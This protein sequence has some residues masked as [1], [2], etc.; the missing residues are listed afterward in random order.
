MWSVK[1]GHCACALAIVVS[2]LVVPSS[3]AHGAESALIP[4]A[5]TGVVVEV[6]TVDVPANQGRFVVNWAPVAGAVA[7]RAEAR[8]AGVLRSSATVV[9]PAA[10]AVIEGLVGGQRYD[11][12]VRAASAGG[13]GAPSSVVSATALTVPSY[14]S[15]TEVVS[16][17]D[18]VLVRWN[19]PTNNGGAPVTK[20]QLDQRLSA[21][22]FSPLAT[23]IDPGLS[24]FAVTTDTSK[25]SVDD[26]R[27]LAYNELGWSAVSL[28]IRPPNAPRN[29]SASVGEASA[30]LEW[31]PPFV[32]DDQRAI[33]EYEVSFSTR[34]PVART[35]ATTYRLQGLAA[36]SYTVSVA[37]VDVDGT[38][39]SPISVIVSL[40][41]S[42]GGGGPV[43]PD[44]TVTPSASPSPSLSPTPTPSASP[45]P[46]PSPPSPSASPLPRANMPTKVT[47]VRGEKARMRIRVQGRSH[48]ASMRLI[49]IKDGLS[50]RLKVVFRRTSGGD[51][52]ATFTPRMGSGSYPMRLTY[53]QPGPAV[54]LDRA[55]LV[56]RR[57]R[58]RTRL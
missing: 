56:V 55:R 42:G 34:E 40:S 17:D 43:V 16:Q 1:S 52:I 10:T 14:V 57:A 32:D 39:G 3:V 30:V 11:V 18:S 24:S 46:T 45:T 48:P 15:V 20:Y 21:T 35:S 22:A 23:D 38:R 6:G 13:F 50:T 12:T 44:P 25:R 7:Y 33:G 41:G 27:V 26:Y 53:V 4:P 47:V 5:P 19:P 31:E 58:L 49:V 51:V 36:G 28:A 54:V 29:L 8:S 2:G 37:A 9:A